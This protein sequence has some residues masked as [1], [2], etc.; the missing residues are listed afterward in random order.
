MFHEPVYIVLFCVMP[1][2]IQ[3][4]HVKQCDN[5]QVITDQNYWHSTICVKS[6]SIHEIDLHPH[7]SL[8]YLIVFIYNSLTWKGNFYF[9]KSKCWTN[10]QNEIIITRLRT[11]IFKNS[12]FCISRDY[13]YFKNSNTLS[14]H[15]PVIAL[16]FPKIT[17]LLLV[18]KTDHVPIKIYSNSFEHPFQFSK[19]K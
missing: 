14:C 15:L 6:D 13:I 3:V 11:A 16:I 12:I 9:R 18:L 5:W 1:W 10:M 2:S 7:H 17:S 8:I 19:E 4:V